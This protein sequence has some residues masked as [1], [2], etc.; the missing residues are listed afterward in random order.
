MNLS[1]RV[2][3]VWEFRVSHDQLLIRSARTAQHPQNLDVIFAG[4]DY[5][6]LPTKLGEIEITS[7]MVDDLRKVQAAFREGVTERDV[8]VIVSGGRRFVVV[9]AKMT[10]VK[11]DLDIFE[12][13]LESF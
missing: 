8:H 4:V 7:P 6:E 9:A 2:F 12:S 5:L 3:R 13:S 1:E 11:N 10:V